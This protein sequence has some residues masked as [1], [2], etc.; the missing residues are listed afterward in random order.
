VAQVKLTNLYPATVNH[1]TEVAHIRRV[2]DNGF[3]GASEED[4]P[5]TASEDFSFFLNEKPGAFFCLGTKR[6]ED[7]TLHS[8]TYDFN[9]TCTA[10][11]ALFWIRLAEDRLQFKI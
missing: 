3:G 6:K 10:T 4:L 5:V 2:A 1:K 8:S 7:E 11:G 9:D